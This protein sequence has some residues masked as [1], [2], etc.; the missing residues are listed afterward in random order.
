VSQ[1]HF[2]L[3]P[4]QEFDAR[5]EAFPA[6]SLSGRFLAGEP[7]ENRSRPSISD[8]TTDLVWILF[9]AA[10]LGGSVMVLRWR[11]EYRQSGWWSGIVVAGRKVDVG[12][13]HALCMGASSCVELVPEVFHLNWSKKKSVFD[14]APLEETNDPNADPEKV[15]RAAQ[16]C[17]YRAIYLKD[18][19]TGERIF[20]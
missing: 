8:V 1:T 18:A 9:G 16:S 6:E 7:I 17:P 13:D 5:D 12:V 14:P 3:I 19:A 2:L 20:P 11:S 10:V 4:N 15:F